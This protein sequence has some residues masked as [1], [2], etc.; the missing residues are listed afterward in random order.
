MTF[1]ATAAEFKDDESLTSLRISSSS[2]NNTRSAG[3]EW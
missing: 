3:Y 1:A 2:S